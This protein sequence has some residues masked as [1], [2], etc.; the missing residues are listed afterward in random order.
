MGTTRKTNRCAAGH[1]IE[2]PNVVWELRQLDRYPATKA[3]VRTLRAWVPRCR[4]CA[5]PDLLLQQEPLNDFSLTKGTAAYD[6][7]MRRLTAL[8]RWRVARDAAQQ[9]QPSQ[10][11]QE[12]REV[13]GGHKGHTDG[14]RR[15]GAP[16]VASEAYLDRLMG[17]PW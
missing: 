8:D 2:K 15:T 3:E 11:P 14:T 6:D 13:V 10:R 16:P 4:A 17:W 9:S 12:P 7:E 1:G 5:D